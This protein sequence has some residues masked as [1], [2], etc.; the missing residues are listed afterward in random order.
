MKNAD[1]ALINRMNQKV[2]DAGEALNVIY[3]AFGKDLVLGQPL[4]YGKEVEFICGDHN[5]AL[6]VN[7]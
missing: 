4:F 3:D 5:L 7:Y 6:M 2:I 1:T